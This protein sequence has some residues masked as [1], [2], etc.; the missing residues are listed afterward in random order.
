MKIHFGKSEQFLI[1]HPGNEQGKILGKNKKV[2]YF[3]MSGEQNRLDVGSKAGSRLGWKKAFQ[4]ER[5]I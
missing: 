2:D 3:I 4:M 1:F 5:T